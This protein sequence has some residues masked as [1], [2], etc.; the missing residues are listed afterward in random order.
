MLNNC[1]YVDATKYSTSQLAASACT[2]IL[3]KSAK[4][5]ADAVP[6]IAS[7][8]AAAPPERSA[9]NTYDCPLSNFTANSA[10][11]LFKKNN[12]DE[13]TDSR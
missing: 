2:D 11:E 8:V 12:N 10:F 13:K 7:V 4:L 9:L 5:A 1:Y 3:V 6:T